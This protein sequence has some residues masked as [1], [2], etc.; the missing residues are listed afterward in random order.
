MKDHKGMRP[1]DI[2]ILLAIVSLHRDGWNKSGLKVIH[3]PPY[4]QN[5][6]LAELLK[7]S[8]AE[9]SASIHRSSFSGLVDMSPVKRVFM[10]SLFEF[11]KF[12]LKYVFP[13]QPGALVRGVPTGHSAGPLRS[14]LSF[15]EEVV[16][17]HSEGLVRG[18]AIIPLYH[19]VPAI[20]E[21]NE[22][23]YELLALTDSLRIGGAREK[24]LATIELEKRFFQ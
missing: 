3:R 5:K 6:D 16:W 1:Q 22:L 21:K 10:Q 9:I 14:S 7:I 17:E 12:G 8:T 19:T 2:V 11:L 20:V 13:V 23:L 18:Q 4:P 24:D 15:Q